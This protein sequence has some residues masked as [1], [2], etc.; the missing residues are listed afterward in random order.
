MTKE[1][2]IGLDIETTGLEPDALILE[3]ALVLFNS[4]LEEEKHIT[5]TIYHPLNEIHARMGNYVADMHTKK[6]TPR[7]NQNPQ[8]Q[9]NTNHNRTRTL[10]L[11]RRTHIWYTATNARLIHPLRPHTHRTPNANPLQQIPLPKHRCNKH[12]TRSRR[13]P[14][15]RNHPASNH[16]YNTQSLR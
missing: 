5:K 15:P 16:R 11:D 1:Y 10:R 13:N 6:R 12:Q 4:N 2:A 3:I 8:P 9:P 7:R 14:L